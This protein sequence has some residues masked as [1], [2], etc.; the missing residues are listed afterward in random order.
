MLMT[1]IPPCYGSLVRC[2]FRCTVTVLVGTYVHRHGVHNGMVWCFI[3]I[4]CSISMPCWIELGCYYTCIS[5][6]LLHYPAWIVTTCMPTILAF[7]TTCILFCCCL[8]NQEQIKTVSIAYRRAIQV[9]LVKYHPFNNATHVCSSTFIAT[10]NYIGLWSLGEVTVCWRTGVYWMFSSW[11][12][13]PS[14]CRTRARVPTRISRPTWSGGT[15][16]RSE[17]SRSS[18][19][20]CATGTSPTIS[21]SYFCSKTFGVGEDESKFASKI[22]TCTC[23]AY[24]NSI[25]FASL[26]SLL[27]V[28]DLL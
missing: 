1:L 12:A 9:K 5:H 25:D 18:S 2:R 13:R 26:T 7:Y 21:R 16:R 19:W 4:Y 10:C 11:A 22:Q 15:R 3:L 14:S 24:Q 27:R 20:T 28:M 6:H 8:T 17:T 23:T